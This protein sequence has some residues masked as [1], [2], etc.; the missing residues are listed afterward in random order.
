MNNLKENEK[1]KSE[2]KIFF[3]KLASIIVAVVI[4][5]NLLFNIIFGERLEQIDEILSL[6]KSNFRIEFRDKIRKELE[7]GLNK[8]KLFYE[9]DKILLYKLYKKIISEFEEIDKT[10]LN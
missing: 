3:I 9:K 1:P 7:Q 10:Q 5:I 4:T 8:D 6:N 2:L